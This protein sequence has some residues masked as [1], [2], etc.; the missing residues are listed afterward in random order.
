MALKFYGKGRA[1]Q[2]LGIQHLPSRCPRTGRGLRMD[3]Q[4]SCFF[5]LVVRKLWLQFTGENSLD[6]GAVFLLLSLCELDGKKNVLLSEQRNFLREEPLYRFCLL[7]WVFSFYFIRKLLFYS[8]FFSPL[9]A[10]IMIPLYI[11]KANCSLRFKCESWE[12]HV[13]LFGGVWESPVLFF[14]Q[15]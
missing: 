10:K 6:S 11:C 4:G 14:K 12:M 1:E 15:C 3:F 13:Y 7:V 9:F 8:F 5:H 2:I